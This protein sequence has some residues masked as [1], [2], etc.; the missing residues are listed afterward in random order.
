[1]DG[2]AERVGQGG[3]R[4]A[5][6]ARW[7]E[8]GALLLLLLLAGTL[9]VWLFRHTEVAARDS[10]GFIRMAWQ[11]QSR[12]WKDVLQDPRTEQ[13]PAYPLLILAASL[14]VRHFLSGPDS[15]LMQL[16]AQLVSVLAGTL[17]VVP[18]YYLGRELFN[19]TA[20]FWAAVLF[21]LL[22]ASCRVLSDALSEAT[23][24]LFAATAL[25]FAVRA[26]RRR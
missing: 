14:P 11:F 8:V 15:V 21:Q 19:R 25:Y 6:R 24:L 4:M 16:G 23:F 13:H 2:Q 17:L 26:L 18:M 22:P 5:R 12:S 3:G 9:R 10:I 20:G 1:M 7:Q